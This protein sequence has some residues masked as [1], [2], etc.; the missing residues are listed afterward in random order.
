MNPHVQYPKF[1]YRSRRWTLDLGLWPYQNTKTATRGRWVAVLVSN[2]GR[3]AW[4]LAS[5]CA[6]RTLFSEVVL[7]LRQFRKWRLAYEHSLLRKQALAHLQLPVL[8][9]TSSVD[10]RCCR[11]RSK[12]P[13]G[14]SARRSGETPD[15]L[16]AYR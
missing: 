14:S 4:V 15:A 12:L 2:I 8:P 6:G 1:V 7:I 9:E 11:I 13:R 3:R 16:S 5:R 10:A